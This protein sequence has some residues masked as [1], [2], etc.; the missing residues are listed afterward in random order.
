MKTDSLSFKE[1]LILTGSPKK[2]N[3][4]IKALNFGL[5]E[6]ESGYTVYLIGSKTYFEDDP[7][8]AINEGYAPKIKYFNFNQKEKLKWT[9]FEHQ[10]KTKIEEYLNQDK[11]SKSIY[12][13]VEH[14]TIGFD[15]GSL[16]VIK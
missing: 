14:I 1:W 7:E 3:R 10:I 5:F 12:N 13:K 16:T 6:T 11:D 2:F 8:W 9:E 4:K 15:E